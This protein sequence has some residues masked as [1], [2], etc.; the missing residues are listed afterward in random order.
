MQIQLTNHKLS[1]NEN[2]GQLYC[3]TGTRIKLKEVKKKT[4]KK[5]KLDKF[6]FIVLMYTYLIEKKTN[7]ILKQSQN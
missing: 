7:E 3:V 4:K 1:T 2:D 6:L 5:N